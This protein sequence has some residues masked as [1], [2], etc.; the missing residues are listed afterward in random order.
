MAKRRFELPGIQDLS[1][2]QEAAR[3]LPKEGQH[4]IVGGPGTGKSVLALIRTRRHQRAGDDYLFLVFNHL[5]NRAN[6][7]LFGEGLKSETWIGWFLKMF[8]ETTEKPV[9]RRPPRSGSDFRDIDWD[10]VDTI[11]QSL[12]ASAPHIERPYLIIDEGQDMPRQFYESLVN[13]GF[14]DFFVVADQ[15]QQ[16]KEENSSRRDIE[17]CLGLNTADVKELAWN[18]RNRYAVARLAREFY[19]GDPASPPPDLPGPAPLAGAAPWL[20]S[21]HPDHLSAVARRILSLADRGPRQLIG[22]IAPNN[23]V[24]ERYLSALQSVDIPLDN[25]RPTIN[26]FHGDHRPDIDFGEGGILVINAQACKGLEFDTVM[27]ADID[28]H[29]INQRDPDAARRLFYV[30]V[31]RAIERVFLF[32]K[33][34][35]HSIET[36]LPTDPSILQRGVI[37]GEPGHGPV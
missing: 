16:I 34:G 27:L 22:V 11:I 18:Y 14:E 12:P 4:L 17:N 37:D 21:Y 6:G 3:A 33:Q 31:A 5:L 8:K 30:M 1:K 36:I 23:R 9:P 7:E 19:T 29:L 10:E 25:P 15:N 35:E 13:L 28:E 24:R 20:Y 32:M 26:T 2:E